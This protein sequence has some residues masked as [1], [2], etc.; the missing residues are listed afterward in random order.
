MVVSLLFCFNSKGYC[1]L[2]EDLKNAVQE[3]VDKHNSAQED[4]TKQSAQ[5][6]QQAV[7]NNQANNQKSVEE[8]NERLGEQKNMQI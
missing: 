4:A 5:V 2:L 8:A 1:G 6:Q 7:E 3:E